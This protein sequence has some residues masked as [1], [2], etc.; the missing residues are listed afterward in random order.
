MSKRSRIRRRR[1]HRFSGWT[2]GDVACEL[3]RHVGMPQP[4][5][6][7]KGGSLSDP[8]KFHG[9]ALERVEKWLGVC[10][11]AQDNK[12][13]K[14]R[15]LMILRSMDLASSGQRSEKLGIPMLK[16]VGQ[17]L[18]DMLI[19]CGL[20]KNFTSRSN[21]ASVLSD[22]LFPNSRGAYVPACFG[23]RFTY[24]GEEMVIDN[25]EK[26]ELWAIACWGQQAPRVIQRKFD[27]RFWDTSENP[28]CFGF[29]VQID[30]WCKRLRV[31]DPQGLFGCWIRFRFFLDEKTAFPPRG[32]LPPKENRALR[33]FEGVTHRDMNGFEGTSSYV[34]KRPGGTTDKGRYLVLYPGEPSG[35]NHLLQ[36]FLERVRRHDRADGRESASLFAAP[37]LDMGTLVKNAPAAPSS[38]GLNCGRYTR[39]DQRVETRD[40]RRGARLCAMQHQI[41][42]NGPIPEY[43]YVVKLSPLHDVNRELKSLTDLPDF[44]VQSVSK[45]SMDG[46]YTVTLSTHVRRIA[47]FL[48]SP[49]HWAK[50]EEEAHAIRRSRSGLFRDRNTQQGRL[51]MFFER[52]HGMSK[53]LIPKVLSYYFAKR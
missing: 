13:L 36:A 48:M 46:R 6:Y 23:I 42:K 43:W 41:K 53:T 15:F 21:A 3:I 32:C 17:C 25:D 38:L 1:D 29:P 9:E 26:G 40:T 49:L 24:R 22:I 8:A 14:D 35:S 20:K 47:Q 44:R 30:F 5:D 34:F 16:H 50:T 4:S 18:Y 39:L 19:G 51:R 11:T 31:L 27:V 2:P 7:G 10:P 45:H 28:I 52:Y 12:P 37:V 33:M